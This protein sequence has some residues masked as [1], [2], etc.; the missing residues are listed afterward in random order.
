MSGECHRNIWK[1]FANVRHMLLK[2]KLHLGEIH[3]DWPKLL[4][5]LE[6]QEGRKRK[7]CSCLSSSPI[8]S[9]AVK[10]VSKI[11]SIAVQKC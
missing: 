7:C 8:I 6:L 11:S 9:A 4:K 1:P 2:I 5:E 10:K 3:D